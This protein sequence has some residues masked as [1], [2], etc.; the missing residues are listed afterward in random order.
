MADEQK[1]A[2][3]LSATDLRTGKQMPDYPRVIGPFDFEDEAENFGQ[4]FVDGEAEQLGRALVKRVE[5]DEHVYT[6]DA[7]VAEK[8]TIVRVTAETLRMEDP[9]GDLQ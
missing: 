6:R 7:A 2:V 3:R 9:L 8:R 5:D 1:Y 4:S